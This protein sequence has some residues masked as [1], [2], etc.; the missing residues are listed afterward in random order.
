[1]MIFDP[2]NEASWKAL[3]TVM[4]EDLF[5][6]VHLTVSPGLNDLEDVF[7]R[8]S[9][10]GV[11]SLSLSASSPH[12]K[13][14]VQSAGELAAKYDLALVWDLPV[15]YSSINPV[16]LELAEAGE[17]VQGA[18]QAWLYVEPDGDVLAGQGIQP[19]LG[20][21]LTGGWESIWKK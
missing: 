15:P 11:R 8:L 17:A 16:G 20:N 2:K 1:M 12:A 5:T 21:L 13:E 7:K 9:E 6:T 18:G 4:P 14:A 3:E 10:M 19:V